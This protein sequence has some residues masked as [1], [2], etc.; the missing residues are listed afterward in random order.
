LDTL[1]LETH[2]EVNSF[3]E[4]DTESDLKR[5]KKYTTK[6]RL[7]AKIVSELMNKCRTNL[8]LNTEDEEAIEKLYEIWEGS[9]Q[10]ELD[11]FPFEFHGWEG[12]R[13]YDIYKIVTRAIPNSD[14]VISKLLE[15]NKKEE[16]SF[17]HLFTILKEVERSLDV[18]EKGAIKREDLHLKEA[19]IKI[20]VA[21][22]FNLGKAYK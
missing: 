19:N 1:T 7:I 20:S 15:A 14:Y 18:N 17:S 4:E 6:E 16:Y 2:Y 12:L 22:Y 9:H 21:R 5:K 13:H 10:G 11:F 8:V 3:E